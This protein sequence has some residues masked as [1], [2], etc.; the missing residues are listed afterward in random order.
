MKLAAVFIPYTFVRGASFSFECD[1]RV[2]LCGSVGVGRF[3]FE[4]GP[5]IFQTKLT[6][7][8]H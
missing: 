4:R 6:E 5:E 2:T 1:Y 3:W 8:Y 7:T